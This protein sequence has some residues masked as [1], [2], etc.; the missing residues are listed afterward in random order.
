MQTPTFL[1]TLETHGLQLNA[2]LQQLEDNFP[3][4]TP[5]PS[6][7]LSQIMYRSGQRSVVEWIQHQLNEKNNGS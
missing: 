4:T 7:T 5:N 3:P 1:N 2:L 6:E